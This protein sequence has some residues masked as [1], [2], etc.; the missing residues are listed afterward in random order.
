MTPYTQ[1]VKQY[2][3]LCPLQVKLKMWQL[4]QQGKRYW[5]ANILNFIGPRATSKTPQNR[6]LYN[7]RICKLGD[8]TKVFKNIG[9]EVALVEI[10]RGP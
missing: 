5:H 1:S 9:Y 6:Q 3:M 7:R 10:Q 4:Q 2:A 8:E